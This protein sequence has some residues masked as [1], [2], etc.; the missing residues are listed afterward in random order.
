MGWGKKYPIRGIAQITARNELT[1]FWKELFRL[2]GLIRVRE[3]RQA[4]SK[5]RI[6]IKHSFQFCLAFKI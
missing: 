4:M 3:N 5:A 2:L 1:E 6:P